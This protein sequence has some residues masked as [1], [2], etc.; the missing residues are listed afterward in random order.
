MLK[1]EINAILN[2]HNDEDGIINVITESLVRYY[3]V[4]GFN[5]EQFQDKYLNY[6]KRIFAGHQFSFLDKEKLLS[7][8]DQILSTVMTI[9]RDDLLEKVEPEELYLSYQWQPESLKTVLVELF[10]NRLILDVGYH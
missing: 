8:K 1:N 10:D 7:Y 5:H 9:V 3:S 2:I 6:L 4:N